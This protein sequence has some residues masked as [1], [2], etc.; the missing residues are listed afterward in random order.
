MHSNA[1]VSSG[2]RTAGGGGLWGGMNVRARPGI[3]SYVTSVREATG[4]T[5]GP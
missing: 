1:A 2:Q 3:S 4:C 5:H